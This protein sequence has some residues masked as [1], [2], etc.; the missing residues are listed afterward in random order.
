MY[1]VLLQ[2]KPDEYKVLF[3]TLNEA[4]AEDYSRNVKNSFVT[5]TNNY[6]YL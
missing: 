5:F 6:N 2:T 4:E 3:V 1:Q